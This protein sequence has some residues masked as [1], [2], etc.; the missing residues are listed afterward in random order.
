MPS[1]TV[2]TCSNSEASSHMIQCEMP[3]RRRAI[4]PAAATA[5]TPTWPR[6][7]SHSDKP[8]VVPSSSTASS[9]LIWSTSV[10]SRICWYAVSMNSP[11]AARA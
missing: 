10:T 8:V 1:A 2:P 9:W 3:F 11:I 6:D 7:H 5:P 4:A